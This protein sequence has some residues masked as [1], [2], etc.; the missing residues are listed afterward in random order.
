MNKILLPALA[1]ILAATSAVTLFTPVEAQSAPPI[2]PEAAWQP[3]EEG[4][5]SIAPSVGVEMYSQN[6]PNLQLVPSPAVTPGLPGSIVDAYL[7]NSYGQVLST[8]SGNEICY[9]IVSLNGPGYLYL[10]EYYPSGST[11][12]GHWLI[13]R[14]YRASAGIWR[15]GPF[16]AGAWDSNGRYIWKIWYQSASYFSTRSLSFIY[17]RGGYYLPGTTYPPTQTVYPPVINSFTSN[18]TTIDQGQAVTLTWSTSNTS[19]A[20]ITPDIGAVSLSGSTTVSPGSTTTYVLTASGSSGSTVS[21]SVT[22]NV[23]PRV[24]PTFTTSLTTVQS[25]QSAML[26]WDAPSA[27]SVDISGVGT[28]SASGSTQVFPDRTTTYTLTS[29]YADGSTYTAY[30]TVNVEQ[31]PYLLYGLIGLLAVGAIVIT[32]LL[33]TRPKSCATAHDG[34]GTHAAAAAATMAASDSHA[35]RSA[36]APP[37]KLTMP[38]G[39][40]L[41]LAGN[42]RSFGR[43]DF[44][45]YLAPDKHAFISRQHVN[46]WYE[47]GSY[48]LEDR[49]STNGTRLNGS[50]IKGAGR[51]ALEDG[52]VIELA[53]KLSITFKT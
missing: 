39:S 5:E 23:M 40:E 1:L 9:L 49:S 20:T 44:D 26:S 13:Y 6:Y 51:Q 11:P 32:I 17:T 52:D 38:D 12:Y 27:Y 42:N 21:N 14:W 45:K 50:D 37:A 7:V 25:G 48:Y 41:L 22:I 46:I 36:E 15:I 28:F 10:W 31:P 18:V 24:P 2:N 3:P 8:L 35:T 29:N 4:T 30:A 33:L 16:Q 53:G 47:E 43:Q 34:T 19:N